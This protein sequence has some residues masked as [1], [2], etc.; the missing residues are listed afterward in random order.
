MPNSKKKIMKRIILTLQLLIFV[1]SL[2]A[3]EMDSTTHTHGSFANYKFIRLRLDNDVLKLRGFTDRYFTNALKIDYFFTAKSKNK[4]PFFG[5]ILATLPER[6]GAEMTRTNLFG[7]SFGMEMYTP[8]DITLPDVIPNDRPYAGLTY[9]GFSCIS[10]E[11]LTGER[12]STDFLI[13]I[14]GPAAMQKEVQTGFHNLINGVEP[15]GWDNQIANDLAL[16]L[17]LE[18]EKLFAAPNQNI[19]ILGSAEMNFGTVTNF[20]GLGAT[21]RFGRFNDYFYNESGLPFGLD[22]QSQSEFVTCNTSLAERKFFKENLERKFQFYA[23]LKPQFRVVIDNSLLEGGFFSYANSPHTLDSD[24]IKRLYMNMEVG[25]VLA[26]GNSFSITYSQ[27]FRTPEFKDA[28]TT[29][30]GAITATVGF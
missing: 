23:F 3:Q 13:G 27:L 7:I 14:I 8:L 25:A 19:E 9:L 24:D 10:N 26:I 29:R 1:C 22:V 17:R 28:L 12:I 30:W 11:F 5:S 2:F 18:Y 6:E 21:F 20:A 15:K 4:K 16:N